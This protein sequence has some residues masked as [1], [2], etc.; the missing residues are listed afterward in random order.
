MEIYC[1]QKKYKISSIKQT[2]QTGVRLSKS[3]I[4]AMEEVAKKK[5]LIMCLNSNR[6]NKFG[7]RSIGKMMQLG[8]C[9]F[10]A[11]FLHTSS[12]KSATTLVSSNNVHGETAQINTIHS[13]RHYSDTQEFKT[14]LLCYTVLPP[15]CLQ[16]LSI[17]R[18]K[19]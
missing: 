11:K 14:L 19:K 12:L 17:R 9:R 10:S 1:V 5:E 18:R 7:A 2:T 15:K 6:F 13:C 8:D 4:D 16:L 3:V